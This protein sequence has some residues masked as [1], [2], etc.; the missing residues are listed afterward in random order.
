MPSLKDV[1]VALADQD[2]VKEAQARAYQQHG[3]EFADVN[4]ELLKQAQEYDYIGRVMAHS[5]MEDLLKQ[6]ADEEMPQADEDEKKKKIMALMAKARGEGGGEE[7]K[8]EEE[9][10]EGEAEKK[11]SIRNAILDRMQHDPNYLAAMV[12]KYSG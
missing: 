12:A 5:A 8:D 10:S 9:E 7:K 4:P 6:A 1:Y 11:A 2:H 3:P